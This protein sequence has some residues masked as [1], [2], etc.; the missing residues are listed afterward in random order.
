MS[1]DLSVFEWRRKLHE[2]LHSAGIEAADL[3]ADL[4]LKDILG[5]DAARLILNKNSPVPAD[6]SIRLTSVLQERLKRRPLAHVL[7]YTE[8][9]GR[10][11]RTDE[12]ALV[13]RKETELLVEQLLLAPLPSGPVL[14]LA[15]GTG[16]AGITIAL[17]KSETIVHC[18]DLSLDALALARENA[19]ALEAKVEFYSS[20]WFE[21][22]PDLRYAAI[23]CNPPYIWL[24]DSNSL[25]PEVL[26]DPAMALFHENP[27]ALYEHLLGEAKER[28]VRGGF[29]FFELGA[30]IAPAVLERAQKIFVNARI[31]ADY[32]GLPRM[33]IASTE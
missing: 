15:C 4:I 11:F 23:L 27:P 8:F 14:D 19:L 28:L 12:R 32:S 16:I 26:F 31:L 18:S 25:E 2:A 29:V 30:D 6:R 21:S 7:G 13:P 33:L 10:R 1:E 20:D 9:Y 3:E 24:R 22:L 5:L 17:E